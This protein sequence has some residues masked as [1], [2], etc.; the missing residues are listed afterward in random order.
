MPRSG[1]SARDGRRLQLRAGLEG[2]VGKAGRRVSAARDS[3]AG[4]AVD[5]GLHVIVD[6]WSTEQRYSMPPALRV[7]GVGSSLAVMIDGTEHPFGVLDVHSSTPSRFTPQDVHFVQAVANILADAIERHAADQALRHRVLHDALTGLP[8]RLSFVEA[9]RS[10]L[11]RGA[12]SPARPSA[13]SSSTSTTS[14]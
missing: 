3:H 9:L 5:S 11:K 6:D 12:S 7:L 10:A 2:Q 13:S 4:A 1:S 14:S 8:N